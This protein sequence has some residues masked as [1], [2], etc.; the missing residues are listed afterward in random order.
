MASKA[1]GFTPWGDRPAFMDRAAPVSW[2]NG[3][4][5]TPAGHML[6]RAAD[7]SPGG[8]K[9]LAPIKPSI[10]LM[11]RY[12]AKLKNLLVAMHRDLLNSIRAQWDRHT[13][14]LATGQTLHAS[15]A[16]PSRALRKLL[17]AKTKIWR[18]KFN[19]L[20]PELADYFAKASKDRIDTQLAR[21]LRQHGFTVK[22]RMTRS[23]Q[24]VMDATV[25]E[26]VSLIQSIPDQYL[27]NVEGVVMR[28]VQTG[29]DMAVIAQELEANYG[30]ERRRAAFIAR[31]Q[32]NKATA[33]LTRTRHLE[34]GIKRAEWLHSRG[35]KHPRPSHVAA[36][37]KLYDVEKGMYLDGV[38]TWPG[39]EINCKCIALAVLPD[40]GDD[41]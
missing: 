4:R 31:D 9:T 14:T 1:F 23:L 2:N 6:R 7:A 24:D 15:D 5:V 26:Q 20:A 39:V 38:W 25:A 36:S 3:V 22:F 13:P 41:D 34:L 32:T 37:G 19:K 10:A 27:K 16:T 33:T 21:M 11:E 12:D 35:G 8:R 29:R 30:V 40:L 18:N 17:N 28:G